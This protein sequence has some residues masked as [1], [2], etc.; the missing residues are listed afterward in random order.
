MQ[1][2]RRGIVALLGF[3][4]FFL[5]VIAV[6]TLVAYCPS[7]C[8]TA[9]PLGEIANWS[10]LAIGLLAAIALGLQFRRGACPADAKVMS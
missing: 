1:G 10:S 5:I 4:L 8:R 2:G 9:W 7:P 6:G 3:D